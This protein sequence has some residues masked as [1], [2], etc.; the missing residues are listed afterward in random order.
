MKT[1]LTLLLSITSFICVNAQSSIK[2][3]VS[4][5]KQKPVK[6]AT[7][8]LFQQKDSSL[9]LSALTADNGSYTFDNVKD[10]NYR[11]TVNMIG[12]KKQNSQR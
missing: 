11:V 6:G 4:D 2:G 3:K 1:I 12:Y 7:V 8:L 10:G 5:E 9:V